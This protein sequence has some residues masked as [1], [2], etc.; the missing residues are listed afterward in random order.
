M[1]KNESF[2]YK[3]PEKDFLKIAWAKNFLR[4]FLGFTRGLLIMMRRLSQR[5]SNSVVWES[6][7]F[8]IIRK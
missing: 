8:S 7:K 1:P 5:F 2:V 4:F 3:K 6:Q